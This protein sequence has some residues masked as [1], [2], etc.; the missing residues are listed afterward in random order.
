M[1]IN[2]IFYS[3]QGEGPQ[4]GKPT[5]F[6]RTQGCNMQPKC[7]FCFGIGENRIPIVYD[8]K[9]N[10]QKKITEVVIGDEIAT[11]DDKPTH[12]IIK[13]QI[14]NVI[15][16]KRKGFYRI[17]INNR[18]IYNVTPEHPFFTKRGIVKCKDLKVEDKI[19][20]TSNDNIASLVMLEKLNNLKVRGLEKNEISA[21]NCHIDMYTKTLTNN[22]KE[23]NVNY[24]KNYNKRNFE[25]LKLCLKHYLFSTCLSCNKNSKLV[26][27]HIDSNHK[28][29][30][31]DNITMLCPSCHNRIH[32]RGENFWLNRRKDNKHVTVKKDMYKIVNKIKYIDDEELEFINFTCGPNNTFLIDNMWVHNCDSAYSWNEGKEMSN[33][34]IYNEINKYNCS[35]IVFTG[36]EPTVQLKEIEEFEKYCWITKNL[37]LRIS[38]E[39]NGLIYDDFLYEIKPIMI[40][41]KKQNYDLKIL[42][43]LCL[44][45]NTY[46][47]FVYDKDLWFEKII[48]ELG[49]AVKNIYIMPEGKTKLEQEKNM[50]E[51]IEYC[52]EK[53]YNFCPRIH[54]LVWNT[55]RAV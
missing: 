45:P 26:V 20:S 50:E 53:G 46:F 29:D 33:E 43:R 21:I 23:N 18:N 30:S 39:T 54:I 38:I 41:P 3:I 55:R 4:S 17:Q 9:N 35:D 22:K 25:N 5:I 6:I 36:G 32:R 52:K 14:K 12:R 34:E 19:I 31:Y 8:I 44:L 47:K 42:K 7:N 28:N 48:S 16:T 11:L 49:L 51:V 1:K 24:I 2:E 37:F 10:K 40:S 13:T 15:K 27:H